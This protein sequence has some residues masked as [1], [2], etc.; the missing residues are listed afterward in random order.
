[1]FLLI[2]MML[3]NC[4]EFCPTCWPVNKW[5][6]RA[7]NGGAEGRDKPPP[8]DQ[9][10]KQRPADYTLD[11]KTV[12]ATIWQRRG[13]QT[14]PN[15]AVLSS[16]TTMKRKSGAY[17]TRPC[18]VHP[19]GLPSNPN[20]PSRAPLLVV[21]PPCFPPS[22]G[23]QPWDPDNPTAYYNAKRNEDER[24]EISGTHRFEQ[25]RKESDELSPARSPNVELWIS[26]AP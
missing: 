15:K 18:C 26:I 9:T 17:R 6:V 12:F 21:A 11:C 22:L 8:S 24:E 19:L 20:S 5:S 13:D 14:E 16:T 4:N 7:S 2:K 3:A 10:E 25:M 1:M 23:R